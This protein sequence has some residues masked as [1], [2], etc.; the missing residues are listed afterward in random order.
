MQAGLHCRSLDPQLVLELT[1]ALR[2]A[3]G[4]CL[5]R[6]GALQAS[7]E[8]ITSFLGSP[9]PSNASR[10]HSTVAKDASE[11]S[12]G[13]DWDQFVEQHRNKEHDAAASATDST[14]KHVAAT[15][16]HS[17]TACTANAAERPKSSEN[18]VHV[19]SV[20]EA[21]IAA[22]T[23]AHASHASSGGSNIS[24]WDAESLLGDIG[25]KNA[26][27]VRHHIQNGVGFGAAVFPG[28]EFILHPSSRGNSGVI[29]TLRTL[30][31][32]HVL[33]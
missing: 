29:S 17:G 26:A 27:N 16:Q 24:V 28:E 21:S 11:A 14:A 12:T 15:A 4:G 13:Q 9:R 5:A 32:V 23:Q 33:Q 7:S 30:I 18:I 19:P 10:K 1:A 25:P 20:A 31:Y 22:A 8:H 6:P 3:V 2:G